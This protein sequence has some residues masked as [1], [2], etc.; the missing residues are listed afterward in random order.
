M[1]TVQSTYSETMRKG[2]PGMIAN[3][4]TQ[5]IITRTNA[6]ATAIAFG[7]PVIRS[8]DHGCVLGT[9]E[10][11]EATSEANAGNTGNGAMGAV[12]VGADAKV[13]DY[14]LTIVEP[15]ANAGAFIV[16]D[17]D[18][19]VIG[20]GDVAA[21]FNAGGLSFTLAD[22]S[23]DFAAGDQFTITLVASE[24]TEDLDVLGVSVRDASLD[25]SN[26]DTFEQYDSVPVMTQG[27]IWV[28]AGATVAAGGAVYWNPATS[29][30]T[31]DAGHLAM[32]GWVYDMAGVNGDIVKIASR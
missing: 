31:A 16:E 18:G 13:G 24:A 30:Y 8:G 6:G 2:L 9:Q 15:A 4:E 12:T 22:G 17:P 11:L 23:T 20:N 14:T 26:A 10:T 27:V 3:A 29:R 21:A 5:N 7:M 32:T 28:T 19:I 1:A 25:V